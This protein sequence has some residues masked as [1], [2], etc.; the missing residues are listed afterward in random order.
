MRYNSRSMTPF[1]WTDGPGKLRGALLLLLTLAG[2]GRAEVAEK[3]AAKVNRDIITRTEWD[4]A[5]EMGAQE[6]RSIT[7]AEE[8]RQLRSQ[9]LDRLISDRLIIQAAL[10]EGLKVTDAEVS[11]QVEQEL[12]A[13]RQRMGSEK[14]F[15]T[16]LKHEGITVDDLRYR[17]TEQLKDRFLYMKMMNKRQRDLESS[18]DLSDEEVQAWYAAHK[19]EPQFRTPPQV[20]ARHMLFAIDAALTG[21]EKA[22]AEQGA[23]K[24]AEA[25]LASLKRGEKFEDVAKTLSEDATTREQGGSLGTFGRGT[26]HEVI[27]QAAFSLKPGQ[28]SGVLVSPAGLHLVKV[29]QII[30]PRPRT[31][32]EKISQTVPTQAPDGS[33]TTEVKEI[34]VAEYAK[35]VLRNERLSKA[36][37]AWVEDLK[38]KALIVKAPD[39]PTRP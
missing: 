2:V 29:D 17:Y 6:S 5:V 31:L 37:L 14:D 34:T 20:A 22:A 8:R 3:I 16:Q 39:D 36:L 19:N 26:Y 18:L 28:V 9:V 11:P 33:P 30:A 7:G 15:L 24:K 1:T 25:A 32:E 10:A 38:A 13:V 21:P 12:D 27:E 23:R 4:D 35:G